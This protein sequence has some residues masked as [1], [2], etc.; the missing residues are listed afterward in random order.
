MHRCV[1]NGVLVGPSR[2][3]GPTPFDFA[4][5]GNRLG[6][7]CGHLRCTKCGEDVRAWTG[8]VPKLPIGRAVLAA[9]R[10]A[11]TLDHVLA[12]G[13]F[14]RSDERFYACACTSHDESSGRGLD[15][16]PE[17][18]EMASRPPWSCGGHPVLAPPDT[19]DGVDLDAIEATVD[20]A[21]EGTAVPGP[22]GDA[23]LSR[24]WHLLRPGPIADRLDAAVRARLDDPRAD[25]RLRVIDFYDRNPG[26]PGAALLARRLAEHPEAFFGVPNPLPGG[27]DLGWWATQALAGRIVFADDAADRALGA[28]LVRE[29]PAPPALRVAL[30]DPD[31]LR[32]VYGI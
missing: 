17:A 21:L 20:A 27:R 23:G 30:D 32:A 22:Y 28:R 14:T 19:I 3:I 7:G 8:A 29:R 24:L 12:D 4:W 25:V 6:L 1:H 15:D 26:A 16:D 11:D 18:W 10:A 5:P 9:I 13:T 2:P 31:R